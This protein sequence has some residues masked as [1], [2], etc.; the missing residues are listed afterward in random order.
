MFEMRKR[1][2]ELCLDSCLAHDCS[3]F[4]VED[5]VDNDY[6]YHK[7]KWRSATDIF[8]PQ[9]MEKQS[10]SLNLPFALLNSMVANPFGA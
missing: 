2:I 5:L 1:N 9:V 4:I 3:I 7:A 10:K 8:G 6:A